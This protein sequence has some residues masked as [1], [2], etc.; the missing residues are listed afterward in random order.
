MGG[1]DI[2]VA[3]VDADGVGHISDRHALG[4]YA[5]IYD[6]SQDA[7]LL[8]ASEEDGVTTVV[9]SKARATCDVHDLGFGDGQTMRA[10]WAVGAADLESEDA[11]MAAH[12]HGSNRGTQSLVITDDIG[13]MLETSAE[14]DT[15][16][17]F[18]DLV[19]KDAFTMSANKGTEYYCSL[20][21]LPE[22]EEKHHITAFDLNIDERNLGK[23]HHMLMFDCTG[24]IDSWLESVGA[25]SLDEL[26]EGQLNYHGRCR[27]GGWTSSAVQACNGDR[28]MS[29]WGVGGSNHSFPLEA[30]M[31]MG[32]GNTRHVLIEWH[33]D[34]PDGEEWI[35]NSAVRVQYTSN[36]RKHD[37]GVFA[38]GI[39][40]LPGSLNIPA[41]METYE[42]NGWCAPEC[43]S[44]KLK[45][46]INVVAIALHTHTVG[47][48]ASTRLIRDGRE[49]AVLAEDPFYDFDMQINHILKEPIVVQPTDALYTQCRY[50]TTGKGTVPMGLSTQ[51]EMCLS[52]ITY[53]PRA[54]KFDN[55]KELPS[56]MNSKTTKMAACDGVMAG[57]ARMSFQNPGIVPLVDQ[58]CGRWCGDGVRNGLELCDDGNLDP[59]DGCDQ[60]CGVENGWACTEDDSGLSTC[61]PADVGSSD[62]VCDFNLVLNA[63]GSVSSACKGGNGWADAKSCDPGCVD[64]MHKILV[65]Y[66]DETV[67]SVAGSNPAKGLL[68]SLTGLISSVV[69]EFN[70]QC[71]Y[72]FEDWHDCTTRDPACYGGAAPPSP[73]QSPH[74]HG[75]LTAD[76]IE[77]LEALDSLSYANS[78]S[79]EGFEGAYLHWT[80]VPPSDKAGVG[81]VDFKLELAGI[82]AVAYVGLALESPNGYGA[83][84]AVGALDNVDQSDYSM[85][86]YHSPSLQFF[87]PE[88]F[89]PGRYH[90]NHTAFDFAYAEHVNKFGLAMRMR[91]QL[92][93]SGGAVLDVLKAHL[94]VGFV[95]DDLTL[96]K[97]TAVSQTFEI[98]VSLPEQ[99]AGSGAC[100]GFATK[101]ECKGAGALLGCHFTDSEHCVADPEAF[102][103]SLASDKKGCKAEDKLCGFSKGK[104]GKADKCKLSK[105]AAKK[106]KKSK[107]SKKKSKKSKK[108]KK[109]KK[110]M[111]S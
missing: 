64:V 76:D 29:F 60:F 28:V 46:P 24:P 75:V 44:S 53:W 14:E 18:V 55:C 54:D 96:G 58:S 15:G 37:I 48:Y 35:D 8:S 83:V 67:R 17:R 39:E 51:D 45:Q 19:H 38:V 89:W 87:T 100:A 70:P 110:K 92:G 33:Y 74:V 20:F 56:T 79:I 40:T 81:H 27:G 61:E 32:P 86:T 23:V 30:G 16:A 11:D 4:F 85:I 88:G 62:D 36:L 10:I 1:A 77:M 104:K 71:A 42:W 107:T 111:A 2:T 78:H 68:G 63:W 95:T 65:C 57:G 12:Y 98:D 5:P 69:E 50:R 93:G 26:P 59:Y 7:E 84:G 22:V 49:V 52:Y 99:V 102:C 91:L 105:K 34:N 109:K 101:G 108:S 43:L 97:A 9:F 6:D 72:E 41:E 66:Y 94:F 82:W 80:A 25:P 90:S 73:P 106:L 103:K 13:L 3:W 31:P 47:Y 21:T